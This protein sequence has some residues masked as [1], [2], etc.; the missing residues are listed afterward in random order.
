MPRQV[1]IKGG[2]AT[3]DRS[4][5]TDPETKRVMDFISTA[6]TGTGQTEFYNTKLEQREG[7]LKTHKPIFEKYRKF[8]ALMLLSNINDI[9]KQL[10]IYNLLN[11]S[12]LI[13]SDI[14][15]WENKI[16]IHS[17]NRMKISRAYKALVILADNKVN[18]SRTRS[19]VRKW[20]GSREN[21]KF[22]VLKYKK[23]IKKIIIH[24]HLHEEGDIW[25]FIFEKKREGYE[26]ELFNN[27]FKARTDIDAVYKLPHS[28]AEGFAATHKVDRKEFLQKIKGKMTDNEKLRMQSATKRVGVKIKANWEKWELDK[29]IKYLYSL[30]R[31]PAKVEEKLIKLAKNEARDIPFK[32]GKVVVIIDNS[33]S[34]Y[35]SSEKKYHP[36]AIS[37][38]IY[39]IIRE[40]SDEVELVYTNPEHRG[41]KVIPQVGGGTDLATPLVNALKKKPDAV[42]ML[43]DGYENKP[44]GMVG[45]VVIAYQKLEKD[46]DAMI[47]QLTPVFAAESEG[48]RELSPLVPSMGL[49]SGRQL[50]SGLL[51]LSIQHNRENTLKMFINFL[52]DKEKLIN[53]DISKMPIYFLK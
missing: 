40:I 10:I 33:G 3:I 48:V 34:G 50:S 44:A 1:I 30:E 11:N 27:Y 32:Y 52:E 42:F 4:V 18:N 23:K 9:S 2:Q 25:D 20:L 46:N 26:D 29:A 39:Y 37:L 13:T 16:I 41:D 43:T 28:V 38:A 53:I 17:L 31:M 24:N 15:D 47:V 36:I 7:L 51:F 14:K 45:Q 6:L 5:A 8:Y 22:E 19:L 49:R 35:G 21:Y 12:R